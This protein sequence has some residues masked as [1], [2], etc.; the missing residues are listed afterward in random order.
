MIRR[1][2]QQYG[3]VE[4][5][6]KARHPERYPG[7]DE[8]LQMWV[9]QSEVDDTPC[10]LFPY[11]EDAVAAA[12]QYTENKGDFCSIFELLPGEPCAHTKPCWTNCAALKRM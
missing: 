10:G 11:K 2:P 8:P 9:V 12:Y 3:C 4:P 1:L 6:L 7:F 5:D